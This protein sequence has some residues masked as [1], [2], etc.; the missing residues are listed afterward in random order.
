[1]K[2]GHIEI[3]VSDPMRSL[4][5]YRDTLG[6]TLE[7]NQADRF[8]WMTANDVVL[9]LRPGFESAPENDLAAVNLVLYVVAISAMLVVHR[10]PPA[11]QSAGKRTLRVLTSNILEGFAYLR[12]DRMVVILLVF[13]LV[14]QFLAMPFQ[15]VLPV[16][17]RD[18][19]HVDAWG[20]GVVSASTGVGAVVGSMYVAARAQEKSRLP[21]MMGSVIAF[22]VL[23][24]AFAQSP[25]FWLAVLLGFLGNIGASVFSTLNNVSIQLVIPDEVRGRVSSF[26]MMSVSLPLLGGLPVTWITRNYGA[27]AAV[28]GACALALV[29][30][31]GL[32][33]GSPRLRAVDDRVREKLQES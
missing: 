10:A 7:V 24:M 11:N 33:V 5:F 21:M 6:F 9:M 13:G 14:P 27:P 17:A 15:Q 28:A 26:L 29:M 31:L 12:S 22:C 2:L 19:W 23:I 3:P 4:A 18:V 30:A 25:W 32:Y 20:L 8:I 1:M 16:F